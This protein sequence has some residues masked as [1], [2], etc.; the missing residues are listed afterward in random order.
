MPADEGLRSNQVA[1]SASQDM[2]PAATA[3]EQGTPVTSPLVPSPPLQM[4]VPSWATSGVLAT[5]ISIGTGALAGI[6]MRRR[7]L[8]AERAAKSARHTLT[9]SL[10][11]AGEQARG[12]AAQSSAAAA[13]AR[14]QAAHSAKRAAKSGRWFRR[15]VLLGAALGILLAPQ[16]GARLRE[17]LRESARQW[18]THGA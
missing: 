13:Q 4:Q 8:R 2:P 12:T 11:A 17:R 15:G 10:Q 1:S 18:F 14:R 9:E 3:A 7:Q 6:M 5:S 16:P